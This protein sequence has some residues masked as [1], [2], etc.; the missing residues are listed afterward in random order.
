MLA[1]GPGVAVRGVARGLGARPGARR[2]AHHPGAVRGVLRGPRPGAARARHADRPGRRLVRLPAATSTSRPG[3]P[4]TTSWPVAGGRRC[5][6]TTCSPASASGLRRWR[7]EQPPRPHSCCCDPGG[8]STTAPDP[9][10][11][12]PGWLGFGVFIALVVAVVLLWLSMRKQLKKVDF[13][14]PGD[15][16]TQRA[17]AARR[18]TAPRTPPKR[19]LRSPL[20]SPRPGADASAMDA[21]VAHPRDVP[22]WHGASAVCMVLMLSRPSRLVRRCRGGPVRRRPGLVRRAAR[23]SYL[24]GGVPPARRLLPGDGADA[25]APRRE[26]A[27]RVTRVTRWR[28]RRRDRPPRRSSSPWR[29]WPWSSSAPARPPSPPAAVRRGSGPPAQSLLAVS[30]AAML[31]GVV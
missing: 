14:V 5:P 25:A 4:R 8:S 26:R 22:A 16:P 2:T 13:E 24:A 19:S 21:R 9:E 1:P 17:P 30:M 10:D 29:C 23:P 15:E 20:T 27:A 12:K 11:V 3:R 28:C 18:A 31:V 6:R 7:H